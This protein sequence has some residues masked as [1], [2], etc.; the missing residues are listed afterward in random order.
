MTLEQ[1]YKSVGGDY[2]GLLQRIPSET[3]IRKFVLKYPNDPTY[4]QLCV[5]I[6]AQDWETAFRSAH[7]LKGVVQNL[8]FDRLYQSSSALTEA[9]RGCMP[10]TQPELLDAVAADYTALLDAIGQL[11]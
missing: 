3:M 1:L 8:G 11:S 4:S 7:T 6:E 2:S 9:L 10:L 5:A